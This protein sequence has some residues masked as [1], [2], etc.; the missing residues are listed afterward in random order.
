MQ[1]LATLSGGT[2]TASHHSGGGTT[3]RASWK[4]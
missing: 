1:E 3:L 4:R 2:F